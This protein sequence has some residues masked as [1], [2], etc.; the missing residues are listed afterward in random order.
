MADQA[1]TIQSEEEMLRHRHTIEALFGGSLVGGLVAG[2]AGILA[3]VG[4][5]GLFP[6]ALLAVATIGV[7]AAFL[8]EGAAIVARLSDLLHEVTEGRMQAVEMG[9]G[10]TAE[11]LAG[12]VGV[13]L[14]IL[15]LLGVI[16]V[17]LVPS[18]VIV[19][20]A[21]MMIGAGANIRI[22]ELS[23]MHR[24][25]HPMARNITHEAV[26]A[27]TGLQV[28][29]GIAAITLGILALATVDR[30]ILSLVAMLGIS[31]V[32]LLTDTAVASRMLSVLH[33]Y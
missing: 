32:F 4:L 7:G 27:T 9:A 28:L 30:L 3:I 21:A 11:T 20:G 23:A 29:A 26:R 2:G 13:T 18:A 17:I 33:R 24:Q 16:P 5:A 14:G 12:L 19:Y 15:A 1:T 31:V 6:Q 10:T 22:N 25:E 8:F